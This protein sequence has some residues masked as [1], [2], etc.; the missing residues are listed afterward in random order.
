MDNQQKKVQK[1]VSFFIENSSNKT[2]TSEIYEV[3][4]TGLQKYCILYLQ[5]FLFHLDIFSCSL[6]CCRFVHFFRPFICALFAKIT[7]ESFGRRGN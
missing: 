5:Y 2:E 1:N 7:Y 6:F 4:L 3:E